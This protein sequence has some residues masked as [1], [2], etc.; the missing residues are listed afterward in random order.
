MVDALLRLLTQIDL[1]RIV[2]L[3]TIFEM[4]FIIFL[5]LQQDETIRLCAFILVFF[6]SV[7]TA[8]EFLIVESIY[9]RFRTRSLL[10]ISGLYQSHPNLFYM[11]FISLMFLLGFPGTPLFW[12]KLIVLS[13]IFFK[14]AFMLAILIL[15]F[16]FFLP[17]ILMRIWISI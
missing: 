15:I 17:V 4:N 9:C 8:I 16:Y 12:I 10:E 14:S 13:T 1:K 7:M 11:S 2:A 5:L 3:L 6:H